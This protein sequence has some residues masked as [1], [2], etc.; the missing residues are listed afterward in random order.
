MLLLPLMLMP[1]Y[2]LH[3]GTD[4]LGPE[5]LEPFP[6]NILARGSTNHEPLNNS[7]AKLLYFVHS[8]SV[9]RISGS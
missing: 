8:V 9:L 1:A 4:F 2:H 7:H 6:P 3:I 5:G